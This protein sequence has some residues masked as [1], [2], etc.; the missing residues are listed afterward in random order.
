MPA[1]EYTCD[2]CG[3]TFTVTR[4]MD[5][6]VKQPACPKCK[7]ASTRQVLSPFYAKTIKKS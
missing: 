5:G 3:N 6:R 2:K 1:Y 7:S 4:P